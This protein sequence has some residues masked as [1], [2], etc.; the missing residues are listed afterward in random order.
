MIGARNVDSG[1]SRHIGVYADAV[2]IPAGHDLIVTSGTPGLLDGGLHRFPSAASGS[3]SRS[4]A[5]PP[6][7]S[8][9]ETLPP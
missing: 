2:R 3:V 7:R 4:T 1:V 5:P 9:E 6:G 8:C